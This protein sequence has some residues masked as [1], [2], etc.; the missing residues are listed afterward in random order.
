[1]FCLMMRLFDQRAFHKA[2][3]LFARSARRPERL[4]YCLDIDVSEFDF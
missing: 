2:H 4:A 1:V 3:R